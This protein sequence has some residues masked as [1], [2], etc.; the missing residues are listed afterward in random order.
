LT[1]FARLPDGTLLLVGSLAADA[2]PIVD[3]GPA[4]ALAPTLF[5]SDDGGSSFTTEPLPFHAVGLAQR[6][7]TVY[8][9]ANNFQ[10]GFALAS[11]TDGGR[12]WTPRLRF[13]DISG[14]KT[15]VQAICMDDC[16]Y[17]AGTTLFPPGTCGPGP[18]VDAAVDAVVDGR[19]AERASSG[20]CGCSMARDALR[21][22]GP[23]AGLLGL[24]L[25]L[26]KRRSRSR[27]GP[28]K[29]GV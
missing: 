16:D 24:V 14:I 20:G 6:G 8:A 12:T 7:G 4:A 26:T 21:P 1:G 10:D 13:R 3:A 28:P 15:C 2:T 23:L 27:V 5:R 22:G 9:A 19:L 29:N 25:L 18:G 17:Q 11:S